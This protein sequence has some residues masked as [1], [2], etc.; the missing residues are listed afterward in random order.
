MGHQ[1]LNNA[2]VIEC[3][4]G[5]DLGSRVLGGEALVDEIKPGDRR[6]A[7]DAHDAMN[8]DLVGRGG[9]RPVDDIHDLP[10]ELG[11]HE[12][13]IPDRNVVQRDVGFSQGQRIG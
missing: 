13:V 12:T 3:R 2:G 7:T 10:D 4:V 6:G 9:E 8:V 1:L 5:L 11:R